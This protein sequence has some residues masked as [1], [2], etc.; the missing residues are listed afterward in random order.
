MS[1]PSLSIIVLSWNEIELTRSCV[2]SIRANTDVSY[3]LIVVDNGS[4][5]AVAEEIDTLADTAI[6]NS[7]NH[8]FAAGMNQGLAVAQGTFVAFLNNDTELPPVWASRLIDTF[9]KHDQVG[10]VVPAVTAAG[11]QISV[12]HQPGTHTTTL[13]PFRHLPSAVLYLMNRDVVRE[14][15]GWGEE[16]LIASREDLDLLF[17]TWCNDLTVILDERVLVDHVSN[18]TARSQLPNRD[19]IWTRNRE[20][21]IDKWSSPSPAVI[22]RLSSCAPE[23]FLTR[24]EQAATVAYWMKQ[25]FDVED[26]AA[27]QV[28][29]LGEQARTSAAKASATQQELVRLER[30]VGRPGLMRR[31]IGSLWTAVRRF[32]PASLRRRLFRPFRS[33]YYRSYPERLLPNSQE[34]P[35]EPE[36]T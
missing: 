7:S 1:P 2:K 19:E 18:A 27:I 13:P 28:A 31:W 30:S 14:L 26:Q 11:N 36:D 34:G 4:A 16:Y 21:F 33:L 5:P 20:V 6:L 10:I 32:V 9:N 3:E 24:L 35:D 15:G 23:R 8:G 29:R 22:P 12:R 25:R 17:K